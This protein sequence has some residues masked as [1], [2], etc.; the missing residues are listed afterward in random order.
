[1]YIGGKALLEMGNLSAYY[2]QVYVA[3]SRVKALSDISLVGDI[4]TKSIRAD[5]L[6][7]TEYERL[8]ASENF[9]DSSANVISKST[10]HNVVITL[11]N[12]RSFKKHYLDVRYDSKIVES[13][14][15]AFTKTRV[16][17]QHN[18]NDIK[19]ALSEFQI[20]LRIKAMISSVWQFV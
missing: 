8:R 16:K 5:K 19:N 9:D 3:L 15:M 18:T 10:A 20:I 13:D 14:I 17:D 1:M 6:I 2:G 12:I 7:E 11:L 4:N